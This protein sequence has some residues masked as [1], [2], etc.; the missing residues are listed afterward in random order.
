MKPKILAVSNDA[1]AS[2]YIAHLVLNEFDNADWLI[3]VLPDSPAY[4]IFKKLKIKFKLIES[5]H[6]LTTIVDLERPNIILYGT[7]WQIDFQVVVENLSLSYKIESIALIDH[8]INYR[9]RFK[10]NTFPKNIMVM[11]DIASELAK[12]NFGK[13]INIIQLKCHYLENTKILFHS[14]QHK[15]ANSIV[16]ISEPTSEIAKY[17]LG[18]ENS[19]GFTEYSVLDQLLTH[20]DQIIVRLHPSDKEN[21]YDHIIQKYPDKKITIVYP[22]EEE[23][24]VTLSKS[25]LTIGF[26][27]MALFISYYLGIKTISYM[28]TNKRDLTIPM[29]KTYLIHDLNLLKSVSFEN[30]FE[31][32]LNKN[33][34]TF[35][36]AIKAILGK[37]KCIL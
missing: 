7:G 9:E 8:W 36:E 26:D 31:C 11:D 18:H 24:V 19:Y 33:T 14:L 1:G 27:G 3:C 28:P 17:N 5:I 13:N 25:N 2:E 4:K 16:F 35:N 15:S 32:E 20:F 22:Y 30:N 37:N 29:P 21:K 12:K 10:N 23:L 6:H 34:I